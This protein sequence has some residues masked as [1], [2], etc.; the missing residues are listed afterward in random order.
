MPP[1]EDTVWWVAAPGV[2]DTRVE[3][4]LDDRA[5]PTGRDVPFRWTV[6]PWIE[7]G[8]TAVVWLSHPPVDAQ[9]E[10]ESEQG[11]A[12]V[13]DAMEHFA[14]L[15]QKARDYLEAE[16]PMDIAPLLDENFDARVGLSSLNPQHVKLIETGRGV[17]AHVRTPAHQ[18]VQAR[19]Q[20]S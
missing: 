6:E 19:C 18:P 12:E 20:E 10:L 17:G 1:V 15:A 14:S 9:D 4:D 11:D 2:C 3:L 7:A 16:R 5:E 13:R 8:G